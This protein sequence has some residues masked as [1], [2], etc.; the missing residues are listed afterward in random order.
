ML[1][2]L[3]LPSTHDGADGTLCAPCSWPWAGVWRSGALSFLATSLGP[4]R[5]SG[6]AGVWDTLRGFWFPT[7][8]GSGAGTGA[9]SLYLLRGKRPSHGHSPEEHPLPG[10]GTQRKALLKAQGLSLR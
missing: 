5:R 4:G 3:G 9:V 6:K 8:E 2:P 1:L 10:G 7:T